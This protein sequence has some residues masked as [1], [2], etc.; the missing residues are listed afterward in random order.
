[1]DIPID[2]SRAHSIALFCFKTAAVFD[3]IGSNHAPFF[4]KAERYA[5]RESLTIPSQANI[6]MSGFALMGKGQIHTGYFGVNTTP[7]NFY[8]FF[9]CTYAVGHFVFQLVAARTKNMI[10]LPRGS[11]EVLAAP[12][13][14][15]LTDGFVWPFHLVLNSVQ[16][17]DL[18]S[19][20]WKQVYIRE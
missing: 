12:F 4:T 2:R 3:L 6:W 15:R 10:E 16:D 9:V 11:F 13:W 7:A 19:M 8:R 1:L 20:R 14:P 17:F 18:F 5:F